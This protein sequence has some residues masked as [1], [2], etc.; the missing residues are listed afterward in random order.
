[1]P[2]TDDASFMAAMPAKQATLE[3]PELQVPTDEPAGQMVSIDMGGLVA[4]THYYVAVRA[5]DDCAG[6]GPIATAEL[7]TPKRQF[8][9]VTPCFVATAAYGSPL[10][11][12]VGL[13]RELRD[14]YLMSNAVGRAAVS[15]YYAV[16]PTF[17]DAIR[18]HDGLRAAARVLLTPAVELARKLH[19]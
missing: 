4:E 11:H 7:T 3:A 18:G 1:V 14:R 16:G 8:A 9:T 12:D 13:L 6:K 17:A 2:I 15:A 5:M 19:D 10:A